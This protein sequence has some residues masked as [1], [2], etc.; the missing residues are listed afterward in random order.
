MSD[1][2][3]KV[4]DC[5]GVFGRFGFVAPG[6]WKA[7]AFLAEMDRHA[8]T[9]S[10]I[11]TTT[12]LLHDTRR[13]NEALFDLCIENE[14]RLLP[15]PVSNPRWGWDETAALLDAGAVGLRLC[16]SFQYY[17]LTNRYLMEPIV[18]GCR[19]RQAT[20]FITVGLTCCADLYPLTP[21]MQI[22]AFCEWAEG[23]PI[24]IQ[25]LPT[26]DTA[27]LTAFLKAHPSVH[28]DTTMFYAARHIEDLVASGLAGQICMGTAYGI[29]SPA[30]GL[31]VIADA[32]IDSASR[33]QMLCE[34]VAKLI[35]HT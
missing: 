6:E 5:N 31:S 34:N 10:I 35:P 11:T 21:F 25:G 12:A 2:V 27:G 26:T 4:I 28:V 17:D 18:N 8:I 24:V 23:M 30:A 33:A 32:E 1:R 22:A 3:N 19:E 14:E 9:Q 13:G 7:D 16:P 20:L 15:L 29:Q